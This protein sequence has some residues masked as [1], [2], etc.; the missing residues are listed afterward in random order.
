M[1]ELKLEQQ[2]NGFPLC[3]T[4]KNDLDAFL[5]YLCENRDDLDSKL[6]QYNGIL[7]RDCGLKTAQGFH[8]IIIAT[9]LKGMDYI[10]GAAVRTQLTE[11]VF[12]ANESPSS[13]KIPFHHEMAQTPQPPTHLFFFCEV[14]PS[15]GGEVCRRVLVC[16]VFVYFVYLSTF[17]VCVQMSTVI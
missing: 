15:E 10:G 7:F 5:K 13:E 1:D 2:R 11:R 16:Y 3:L 12:T 14:P 17:S 8:D 9:G 4:C 6:R